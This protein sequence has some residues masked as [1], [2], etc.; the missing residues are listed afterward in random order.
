MRAVLSRVEA[1]EESLHVAR[2]RQITIEDQLSV[3]RRRLS[4]GRA[5]LFTD[6][7]DGRRDNVEVAVTFLALLELIKRRE[8]QASQSRMFGPIEI[9]VFK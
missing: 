5:F 9:T 6:I 7:V 3:L 1:K 8:A 2:P 4:S